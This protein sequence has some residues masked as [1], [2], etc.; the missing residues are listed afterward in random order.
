MLADL[1]VVGLDVDVDAGDFIEGVLGSERLSQAPS[2]W[3]G[4]VGVGTVGVGGVMGLESRGPLKVREGGASV[5]LVVC[6]ER[7]PGP[8]G[9]GGGGRGLVTS[10]TEKADPIS[11]NVSERTCMRSEGAI[12]GTCDEGDSGGLLMKAGDWLRERYA[13]ARRSSTIVF[14]SLMASSTSVRARR[15]LAGLDGAVFERA[16]EGEGRRDRIRGGDSVPRRCRSLGVRLRTDSARI[17]AARNDP[18]RNDSAF[19][20]SA[21]VLGSSCKKGSVDKVPDSGLDCIE[22]VLCTLDRREPEPTGFLC[23]RYDDVEGSDDIEFVRESRLRTNASAGACG[24]SPHSSRSKSGNGDSLPSGRYIDSSR[25]LKLRRR[26]TGMGASSTMLWIHSVPS[27]PLSCRKSVGP[28][29]LS[30]LTLECD[31]LG[32]VSV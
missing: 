32:R 24:I 22:C 23:T 31:F 5:S 3:M 17:D 27:Y 26:R 18:A 14:S 1:G 25:G 12:A 29:I 2:R 10:G 8:G 16:R 28:L 9:G 11:D 6:R 13:S 20:D 4:V 19:I 30:R 21:R 15:R 7:R